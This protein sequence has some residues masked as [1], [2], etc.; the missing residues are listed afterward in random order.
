MPT[1]D[2]K[3]ILFSRRRLRKPAAIIAMLV[4]IF[5]G[6]EK[7]PVR[8][9]PYIGAASVIDGDTIDIQGQ[10]F[11]LFG[12]DAPESQ[13]HCKKDGKPYLCGKDAAFALADMIGRQNVTCEKQDMDPY[14]R[15]VA[16]CYAGKTEINRWMVVHGYAL[17][18]RHYSDRYVQ[19]EL[20]AKAAKL[21]IW[22]GSFEKP[23]NYR[24]RTK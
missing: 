8:A 2:L 19:D 9:E 12:I 6:V 21:G 13:Q 24:H 10:R 18:Y 5:L 14:H 20:D 15:I 7:L 16:I 4:L 1:V 23:W 3:K 11:R 22:A 17:A